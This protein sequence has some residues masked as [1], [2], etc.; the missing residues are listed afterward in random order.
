MVTKKLL[1]LNKQ[2]ATSNFKKIYDDALMTLDNIS[3]FE[4]DD[5]L[6]KNKDSLSLQYL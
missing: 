2:H 4:I 6:A 1:K 3:D 5:V